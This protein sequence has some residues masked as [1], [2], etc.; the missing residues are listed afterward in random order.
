MNA[1]LGFPSL[2]LPSFSV[3]AF[4]L[5]E[6]TNKITVQPQRS[7]AQQKLHYVT[8]EYDQIIWTL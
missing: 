1:L 6:C 3:S 4:S 2:Q 7:I 5:P 8:A